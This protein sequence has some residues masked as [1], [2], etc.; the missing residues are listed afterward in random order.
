[1]GKPAKTGGCHIFLRGDKL[2][3]AVIIPT[4]NRPAELEV[5]I[6]SVLRQSQQPDELI[7]VD[8]GSDCENIEEIR[9]LVNSFGGPVRLIELLNI[10]NGHGPAYSRNAGIQVSSS[11]HICFLDDDDYWIDKNYLSYLNKIVEFEDLEFDVHFCNQKA[12]DGSVE[13]TRSIWIAEL[14]QIVEGR[15][16]EHGGEYI[17]SVDDILRC[18]GFCH[19]NT[20]CVRK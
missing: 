8:D 14:S 10:K 2:S 4:R 15:P 13:I 19:L 12:F 20:T 1:L 17:V 9:N 5:A 11:T 6:R 18:T 3:F 16:C 7:V